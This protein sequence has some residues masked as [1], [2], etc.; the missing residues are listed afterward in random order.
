MPQNDRASASPRQSLSPT[1][2][3]GVLAMAAALVAAAALLVEGAGAHR[4]AGR[5]A[6]DVLVRADRWLDEVD[7]ELSA[8]EVSTASAFGCDPDTRESLLR[9]SIR[10]STSSAFV[11]VGADGEACGPSARLALA[12]LLGAAPP[13]AVA[14]VSAHGGRL[15]LRPT[16]T[17]ARG[18]LA[19]RSSAD[20]SVV[21][22]ILERR[23]IREVA[24]FGA[25]HTGLPGIVLATRD[26][27]PVALGETSP[28]PT[29]IGRPAD[30]PIS[31]LRAASSRWPIE[32]TATVDATTLAGRF[33]SAWP[34][35]LLLWAVLA[36]GSIVGL[37]ALIRGRDRPEARLRRALRKRR[38]EPVVQPIVDARTGR[39]VGGEVL[40]RLTHPVRGL[41]S[42]YEFIGLAEATGLIVPI[43][44]LLLAKARDQLAPIAR[45]H[46]DLYFSFNVAPAQLLDPGLPARLAATF[47]AASL[48][49]DRVLLEL[50]E[51]DTVDADA[52][53]GLAALRAQGFRTALDDFGTGH[54]SLVLLERLGVDRI[55]LDREFVRR[56]DEPGAS[57]V[58]LESMIA[59]AQRLGTPV[60]AEGIETDTQWRWLADR[61]VQYLQGYL[62]GRPMRVPEFAGFVQASL[63]GVPVD[64]TAPAPQR[65]AGQAAAFGLAG[66]RVSDVDLDALVAAMQGADGL[67]V[68]DRH[69]RLATWKHC[70]V[71]HEAVDWLVARLGMTRADAVRL[72]QR[73]AAVGRVEHV[74]QEHDFE[75]AL[76]FYRFVEPADD[77]T[78]AAQG[79]AVDLRELARAMRGPDGPPWRPHDWRGV[80]YHGTVTG[81]R[82]TRWLQART[83]LDRDAAQEIGRALLRTGTIR[84]VDDERP[85]RSNREPFRL[86]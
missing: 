46:P 74:A 31:A 50:T 4:A 78:A 34:A 64:L 1:G 11:R 40:L 69:W 63:G 41:V 62:F 56:I 12:D 42:P 67:D 9:A 21:V 17:L 25:P 26:T 52:I 82:L 79:P 80:R 58:V 44:S 15:L 28:N 61:G 38:F 18:L 36:G 20:G 43:S 49:P 47:D 5:L 37:Q 51:R 65:G 53:D 76:L 13:E 55:K 48:P 83:G 2:L 35:W 60:I 66:A 22:A 33:E 86:A 32:V 39:C 72:G 8:V 6:D 71:G 54:S 14:A 59:M 7:A 57:L 23:R 73:M 10:S 24:D 77:E 3:L 68:R 27:P 75:D 45:R 16:A 29:R 84:H 30:V 19:L 85:Y 70:F 81:A